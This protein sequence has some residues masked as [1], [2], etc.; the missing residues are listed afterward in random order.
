MIDLTDQQ[1]SDLHADIGVA[2][3]ALA[4][5]ADAVS[6]K[7]FRPAD[8]A[9][10]PDR[11]RRKAM[12]ALL[13]AH[14]H[15]DPAAVRIVVEEALAWHKDSAAELMADVRRG[16]PPIRMSK[17]EEVAKQHDDIARQWEEVGDLGKARTARDAALTLRL[18]CDGG[19]VT[20]VVFPPED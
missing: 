19:H 8:N 11:C 20:P 7:I 3:D 14:Y 17:I 5:L 10:H 13:A 6:K 1:K 4:A 2:H 12:G 15:G 16:E 9:F 18:L